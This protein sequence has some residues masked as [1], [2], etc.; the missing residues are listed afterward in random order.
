M[1]VFAAFLLLV[2]SGMAFGQQVTID[3]I[4]L[5]QTM[6]Q[7]VDDLTIW[8][9]LLNDEHQPIT[10]RDVNLSLLNQRGV[11]DESYA[12]SNVANTDNANAVMTYPIGDL[13]PS[14]VKAPEAA[15]CAAYDQ[16]TNVQVARDLVLPAG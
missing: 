10:V 9:E 8:A 15:H 7:G 1:K 11:A 6:I 4:E 3:R 16:Y 14:P 5:S 13:P 12:G 2:C